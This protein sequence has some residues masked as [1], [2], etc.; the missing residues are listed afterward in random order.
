MGIFVLA[1]AKPNGIEAQKNWRK[2]F[3]R[4]S[5]LIVGALLIGLTTIDTGWINSASAANISQAD[6]RASGRSLISSDLKP[7]LQELLSKVGDFRQPN[8]FQRY[9]DP[10]GAF[11]D[12]ERLRTA[13]ADLIARVRKF[14]PK[15]HVASLG[16]DAIFIADVFEALDIVSGNPYGVTRLGA[17]SGSVNGKEDQFLAHNRLLSKPGEPIKPFVAIDPTRW[18]VSSQLRSLIQGAYKHYGDQRRTQNLHELVAGISTQPLGD[19]SSYITDNNG[20]LTRERL[21]Q[22]LATNGASVSSYVLNIHAESL[23]YTANNV[24]WH[25]SFGAASSHFGSFRNPPPGPQSSAEAKETILWI[26]YEIGAVVFD[27]DFVSFLK[28]YARQ[29]FQTDLNDSLYA[30]LTREEIAAFIQ[31]DGPIKAFE[32]IKADSRNYLGQEAQKVFLSETIHFL[33][34]EESRSQEASVLT[35]LLNT[36]EWIALLPSAD[37]HQSLKGSLLRFRPHL[38][39]FDPRKAAEAELLRRYFGSPLLNEKETVQIWKETIENVASIRRY[40][41]VTERMKVRLSFLESKGFSNHLAEIFHTVNKWMADA[42]STGPEKARFWVDFLSKELARTTAN[43]NPKLISQLAS[44][45]S[46]LVLEVLQNEVSTI[47]DFR[48]ITS[49]ANILADSSPGQEHLLRQPFLSALHKKAKEMA[50]SD[51]SRTR[52]YFL[53]LSPYTN[54]KL[55]EV[56]GRLFVESLPDNATLMVNEALRLERSQRTEKIN[57]LLREKLLKIIKTIADLRLAHPFLTS[58]NGHLIPEVL[59]LVKTVLQNELGQRTQ[60]EQTLELLKILQTSA[61]P[62]DVLCFLESLVRQPPLIEPSKAM[63]FIAALSQSGLK[64][65]QLVLLRP[66]TIDISTIWASLRRQNTKFETILETYSS[67]IRLL[68]TPPH[69]EGLDPLIQTYLDQ[70]FTTTP[71][72]TGQFMSRILTST[73]AAAVTFEQIEQIATTPFPNQVELYDALFHPA[74]HLAPD[75]KTAAKLLRNMPAS[76][77]PSYLLTAQ[78]LFPLKGQDLVNE[79][80]DIYQLYHISTEEIL[81][82]LSPDQIMTRNWTP[83]EILSFL[84]LLDSNS[85]LGIRYGRYAFQILDIEYWPLVFPNDISERRNS[86]REEWR[87]FVEKAFEKERNE[88]GYFSATTRRLRRHLGFDVPVGESRA[89]EICKQNLLR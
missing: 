22:K 5:S 67:L 66:N 44:H 3:L 87:G 73:I 54:L 32:R 27:P 11:T 52:E 36:N 10:G 16:R 84:Q 49:T 14:Y 69:L 76:L 78:Q 41:D 65:N 89:A 38:A 24:A 29:R 37:N 31:Q 30:P 88:L 60:L 72:D 9:H 43:K 50:P 20:S 12:R 34:R 42:K 57:Q 15:H 2:T 18:S 59:P 46:D 53:Q 48:Q 17:S 63:E 81:S 71:L 33:T 86:Y 6:R 39:T 77:R 1:L 7:T 62:Y 21:L 75:F 35:W 79:L 26:M 68:A 40:P 70:N 28:Q 4:R 13:A 85:E 80:T 45:T 51:P 8:P 58:A 55:D 61:T 74:L 23:T 47:E 56:V 82:P 19:S 64:W 83:E 25:G